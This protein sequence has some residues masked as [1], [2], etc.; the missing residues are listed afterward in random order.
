MTT[1]SSITEFD[2]K[3]LP[4]KNAIER[5]RQHSVDAALALGLACLAIVAILHFFVEPHLLDG[6]P[7]AKAAEQSCMTNAECCK[8][9]NTGSFTNTNDSA[10]AALCAK[11][12]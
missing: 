3:Y 6:I 7:T 10:I 12:L 4:P 9:W 8:E 11:Y 2:R 5:N 1:Y